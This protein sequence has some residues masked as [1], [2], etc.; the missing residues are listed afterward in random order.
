MVYSENPERVRYL[1]VIVQFADKI[2]YEKSSKSNKIT[3]NFS[4]ISEGEN[5]Q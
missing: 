1:S 4:N 5:R 2:D 3:C